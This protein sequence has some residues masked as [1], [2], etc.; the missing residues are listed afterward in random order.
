M[1]SVVYFRSTLGTPG[2]ARIWSMFFTTFK[3]LKLQ[4]ETN[5][6]H[7]AQPASSSLARIV[8]LQK[9]V[10]TVRENS[11]EKAGGGK[12]PES[13]LDGAGEELFS[14]LEICRLHSRSLDLRVDVTEKT[15]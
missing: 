3:R 4:V 1:R 12:I 9:P 15:V 6:P 5:S 2:A 8:S 14:T 10:I 7:T 11:E 13:L